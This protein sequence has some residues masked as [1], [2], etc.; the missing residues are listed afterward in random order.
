MKIKHLSSVSQAAYNSQGL[1]SLWCYDS[2]DK[3]TGDGCACARVY[4]QKQQGMK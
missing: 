4:V 1:K 2:G 3:V